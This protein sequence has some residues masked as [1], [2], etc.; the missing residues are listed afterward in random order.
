[1]ERSAGHRRFRQG[2][3]V[4]Q[5]R[6]TPAHRPGRQRCCSHGRPA[7]RCQHSPAKPPGT[8]LAHRYRAQRAAQRLL[9]RRPPRGGRIRGQARECC[10][11]AQ[12]RRCS[13]V[14]GGRAGAG[15]GEGGAERGAA[16]Q[17]SGDRCGLAMHPALLPGP[18]THRRPRPAASLQTPRW[19]P[20]PQLA[21]LRGGGSGWRR[22]PAA[23][24]AAACPLRCCCPG[25][26]CTPLP[27][28]CWLRSPHGAVLAVRGRLVGPGC[29][30]ASAGCWSH[31]WDDV[32]TMW[33]AGSAGLRG[34]NPAVPRLLGANG[35]RASL[36]W[37]GFDAC[38]NGARPQIGG[39]A[40]GWPAAAAGCRRPAGARSLSRP[41][42]AGVTACTLPRS[43]CACN[44]CVAGACRHACASRLLL[45]A[46][47][48]LMSTGLLP[49]RPRWAARR[50]PTPC[51]SL[52]AA[53]PH[54]ATLRN[55]RMAPQCSRVSPEAGRQQAA[56]RRPHGPALT[57]QGGTWGR[58][59]GMHAIQTAHLNACSELQ[60]SQL[61]RRTS[62]RH[63]PGC[64]PCISPSLHLISVHSD[65][66][67]ASRAGQ[68]GTPNQGS[69]RP[70][71]PPHPH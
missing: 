54:G 8:S 51:S 10:L 18:T 23:A 1:M 21:P 7:G 61:G 12:H 63:P 47:C 34:G 15:M 44:H 55:V 36:L 6:P 42:A 46:P 71:R 57:S 53:W 60:A 2:G 4:A 16:Q 33:G 41:P 25:G 19:H 24:R 28:S 52:L 62:C 56:Q 39:Q 69:P 40:C 43:C 64:E 9:H 17:H 35:G 14:A 58:Q 59:A 3:S 45:K 20:A 30:C 50:P 29:Q 48:I 68:V 66:V 70:A 5:G 38:S 13:G 67:R 22:R 26:R 11:A 37:A 65:A 32:R 31:G 27:S 49:P